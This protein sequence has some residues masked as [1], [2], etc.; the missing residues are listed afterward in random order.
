MVPRSGAWI[1]REGIRELLS[2]EARFRIDPTHLGALDELCRRRV[3]F[4]VLGHVA[5]RLHGAPVEASSVEVALQ[6]GERNRWHFQNAARLGRGALDCL[7]VRPPDLYDRF[8]MDALPLPWLQP[9]RR[10]FN[11]WCDAPTGFLPELR[12]LSAADPSRRDLLAA[13]Q[14]EVDVLRLG[15]RINFPRLR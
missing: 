9:S 6:E 10:M 8:R 15:Y 3:T 5:A 2:H 11:E 7:E 1:D 14:Q 13:V 12:C 4:V